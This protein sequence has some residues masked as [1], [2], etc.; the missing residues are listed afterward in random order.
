MA[1]LNP[2]VVVNVG[3]QISGTIQKLHVNFNDQV[4]A[5]QVL[6]E[7]DPSILNATLKQ[8][9]SNLLSTE[10]NRKLAKTREVRARTL[11]RQRFR[12]PV[13]TR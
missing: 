1:H 4:T 8:S 3:T 9:E 13:A 11:V 5:N 2:V 7:F 6:A 12:R 10:A